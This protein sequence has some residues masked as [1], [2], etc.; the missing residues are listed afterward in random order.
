[1]GLALVREIATRH[2]R[3]VAVV[4]TGPTGTTM[5]MRLPH[6]GMVSMWCR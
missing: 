6:W 2:G 1:M 3:D 4:N 5:R